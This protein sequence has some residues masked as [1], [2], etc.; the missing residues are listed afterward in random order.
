[1][2]ERAKWV[3]VEPGD[4]MACNRIVTTICTA[5]DNV[6][7]STATYA[8]FPAEAGASSHGPPEEET[9][10]YFQERSGGA[11]DCI[12]IYMFHPRPDICPGGYDFEESINNPHRAFGLRDWSKMILSGRRQPDVLRPIVVEMRG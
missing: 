1:M 12:Y 7:D 2:H 3:V 6:M 10:Y 5:V 11:V 8:T 4:L 9:K